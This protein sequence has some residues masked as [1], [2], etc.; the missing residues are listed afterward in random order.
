ASDLP[1]LRKV[2]VANEIGIVARLDTPESYAQAINSVLTRPDGG[3]GLRANLSRIAP[4]YTW[5]TQASRLLD[6]YSK[7]A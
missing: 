2:I 1:Y 5:S 3:A 6:A 4:R 7:L